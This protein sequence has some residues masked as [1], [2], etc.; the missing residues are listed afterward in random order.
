MNTDQ[1]GK[2]SRLTL[3]AFMIVL[4]PNVMSLSHS[5]SAQTYTNHSPI[6]I[7]GNDGF[8]ADNGV[9]AG[10][11]A[12]N[13]PYVISGWAIQVPAGGYG[14]EIANTT[15]YFVITDDQIGQAVCGVNCGDGILLFSI[16]NGQLQ[17]T[18]IDVWGNGIR[19]NT[20][21]NFLFVNSNVTA[22]GHGNGVRVEYSNN[23]QITHN[24]IGA[25]G[26][27][28]FLNVDDSFDISYNSIQGGT[29]ALNGSYLSD[30]TIVG[31]TV[32]AEDGISLDNIA[33]LLIS[34]NRVGAHASI[35]V[36]SCGDV[37][38]DGNTVKAVDSPEIFVAA[39]TNVL[40]SNNAASNNV[41][42]Q[43]VWVDGSDNVNVNSNTLS[44]NAVG[45]RLTDSATG[46]TIT[47]NTISNNQCG[48]QTD[49]TSTPDQNNIAD[50]TFAGNTQ[51]FC[52]F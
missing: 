12:S 27:V 34:Q 10:S 22:N 31:N 50:N 21:D 19:V 20:S 36:K 49:S 26:I 7:T 15:A 8:T 33:H 39:C 37:T 48:I 47:T 24:N 42:G 5:V 14:V 1:V 3:L 30:A 25:N 32:G 18:S 41:D 17:N 35:V 38:I 11:G 43:G 52:S 6:L 23:F 2:M 40:V 29:N 51:D 9:T 45:I 46:N 28:V 44:G 4:V 13:D 16:E